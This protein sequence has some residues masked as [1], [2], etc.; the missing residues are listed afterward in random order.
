MNRPT[1]VAEIVAL[2]ERRGSEHY[3]E[4]VS[5]LEHALQCAALAQAEGAD[6][7]LVVAALL[8]DIG[9]LVVDVQA[10]EGYVMGVDDD[11]HE[12]IGAKVLAPI[13][14]ASVAQPVALHVTAKRYRCTVDPDYAATLSQT[15][16]ETLAAQ[17]GP[18]DA[19]ACSRFAAHPGCDDALRLRTWDDTGKMA[20]MDTPSLDDLRPLLDRLAAAKA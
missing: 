19:E 4:S 3:G 16:T 8:H 14:G 6:D 15:S 1:N 5:Q 20:E 10:D 13:F 7:A 11:D 2:F 17:G 9:H 12:S 18:L